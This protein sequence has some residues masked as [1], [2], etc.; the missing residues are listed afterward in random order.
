MRAK[1]RLQAAALCLELPEDALFSGARVT[2]SG[3]SS[4]LVEGQQGVVELSAERIRL[5]TREGVLSVCG[6]G[7]CLRRLTRDAAL[8]TGDRV[9][10]ATYARPGG[11]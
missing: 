9:D 4:A 3:Q 11:A 7:L 8:I 1:R 5:R 10:T 6:S 2:L